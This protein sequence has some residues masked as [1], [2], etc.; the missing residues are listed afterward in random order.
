ML[1]VAPAPPGGGRGRGRAGV[2]GT[3]V[4]W[5]DPDTVAKGVSASGGPD[6]SPPPDCAPAPGKVTETLV[7]TSPLKDVLLGCGHGGQ[8]RERLGLRPGLAGGVMVDSFPH[9]ET[10]PP[11]D[12]VTAPGK[13][14]E[15]LV[16]TRPLKDVLL[17]WAPPESP[18]SPDGAAGGG[19]GDDPALPL[20]PLPGRQR[21]RRCTADRMWGRRGREGELGPSAM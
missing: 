11:P 17:G 21:G 8:G 9:L 2:S 7:L 15:T 4:T 10:F 3:T 16:S 18:E 5:D 1:S 19:Q 13:V 14:T 20:R 12:C 6:P